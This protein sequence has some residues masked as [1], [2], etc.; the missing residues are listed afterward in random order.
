MSEVVIPR[1][2][3]FQHRMVGPWCPAIDTRI[4]RLTGRKLFATQKRNKRLRDKRPPLIADLGHV[5][6]GPSQQRQL[7]GRDLK[8]LGPGQL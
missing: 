6:R 2:V 5:Q 7:T 1:V 3:L 4:P 8:Q